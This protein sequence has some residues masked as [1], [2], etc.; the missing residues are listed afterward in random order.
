MYNTTELYM[1]KYIINEIFSS[2][3]ATLY[4]NLSDQTVCNELFINNKNN[5]QT[6]QGN[7]M[8]MMGVYILLKIIIH[9]FIFLNKKIE[10]EQLVFGHVRILIYKKTH[11]NLLLQQIIF[12]LDKTK[13][14]FDNG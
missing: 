14:G 13:D 10:L 11:K 4:K 8:I 9:H 1:L 5:L 2:G 3:R 6:N 7:M 12:K